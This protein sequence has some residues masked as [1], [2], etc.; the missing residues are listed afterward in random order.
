VLEERMVGEEL[1]LFGISDGTRVV[2]LATAQ[3]HK[4]VGDGDTGP[5]TGGM[6]AFSP[7]PGIDAARQA[8]LASLFLDPAIAGMAADG[9]PYV[10]VLF[11]G[12]MVTEHGPRLIEYNCRFGDP[13]AEAILPMLECDGL[14]LMHAA[15]NR[16][17]AE[18]PL[19]MRP[20]FAATVVVC[21]TGYPTDPA[22]GVAVPEPDASDDVQ[23]FFAGAARDSHGGLVSTGGRVVAV[24]G[25]GADLDT[26]LT[27]SYRVVDQMTGQDLF[28][29]RDIGWRHSTVRSTA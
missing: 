23:I 19:A 5:N 24:T 16:S 15:A 25:L 28:A 29:R 2:A 13:E 18:G 6:G 9:S 11:A 12:I 7:V 26:A 14:E 10:G 3:D 8:E 20:G 22:R 27:N 17:L 4:R 1:S 21:A